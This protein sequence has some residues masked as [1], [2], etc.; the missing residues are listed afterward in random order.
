MKQVTIIERRKHSY[1]KPFVYLFLQLI[2]VAEMNIITFSMLPYIYK[3]IVYNASMV[4]VIF[5][6]HKTFKILKRTKP[7][8][9]T[10]KRTKRVFWKNLS[11]SS[12]IIRYR[13]LFNR[14]KPSKLSVASPP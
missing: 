5:M 9:N 8:Y 1:I 3:E 7:D 4:V 6:I 11:L 10:S 2:I 12:L 14:T 13:F